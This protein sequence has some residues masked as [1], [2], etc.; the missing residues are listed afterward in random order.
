MRIKILVIS[1]SLLKITDI[2]NDLLALYR[3]TL[4]VW[5][6]NKVIGVR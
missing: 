6:L 3:G 2:I 1:N 4:R 5:G